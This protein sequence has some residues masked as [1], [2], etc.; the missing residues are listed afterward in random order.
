[1]L[2]QIERGRTRRNEENENPDGPV[3]DPIRNFVA[4]TE[5]AIARQLRL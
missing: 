4:L 3:S 2:E 5:P 1:M